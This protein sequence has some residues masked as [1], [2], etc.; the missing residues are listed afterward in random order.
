MGR[1]F[2][3][4]S[5]ALQHLDLQRL[6]TR[7]QQLCID[8]AVKAER[9]ARF[10]KWLPL[11]RA[12]IDGFHAKRLTGEQGSLEPPRTVG[13]GNKAVTPNLSGLLKEPCG[14]QLYMQNLSY[15]G[16]VVNRIMAMG[17]ARGLVMEKDRIVKRKG[18]KAARKIPD[19]FEKTRDIRQHDIPD[20]MILNW[21]QTGVNIVPVGSWNLRK[22]GLKSSPELDL[23]EKLRGAN[24]RAVFVPAICTGELQ[25]LDADGSINDL[26]KGYAAVFCQPHCRLLRKGEED[27]SRHY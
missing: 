10:S 2:T 26:L 22:K 11:T 20:E 4:Y 17:A 1:Q 13:E 5:E 8:F 3:T 23:L 6:S 21:D 19:D 24:T 27:G 9:S 25:P 18:T 14:L 16:G 7:R 12:I 15:A